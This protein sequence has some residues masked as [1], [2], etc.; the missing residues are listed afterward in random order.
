M[1]YTL[2]SS[3]HGFVVG[4]IGAA[5]L[6]TFD[7]R[8]GA[9]MVTVALMQLYDYIFWTHPDCHD[10]VNQI[11]TKLAMMTNILQPIIL[12]LI[13]LPCLTIESK[14]I[15]ALY[16]IYISVYTIIGWRSVE[17]TIVTPKSSPSLYWAWTGLPGSQIACALYVIVFVV[18]F[19][20]SCSAPLNLIMPT[21][22]VLS[23]VLAHHYYKGKSSTGRFW[24]Y[25]GAYIPA[26]LCVY[27]V[28]AGK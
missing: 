8:L 4:A 12:A 6:A 26:L 17:C 2:I 3:L 9:I 23:F 22:T 15:V 19:A 25:F 5:V 14:A 28:L 11:T 24:C 16:A 10:Q 13:Y 21:V 1:C 27:F 7:A 18:V 20:Q